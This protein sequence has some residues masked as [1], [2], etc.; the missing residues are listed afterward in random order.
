[1]NRL[2]F[3]NGFVIPPIPRTG[4]AGGPLSSGTRRSPLSRPLVSLPLGVRRIVAC[5]SWGDERGKRGAARSIGR[6]LRAIR[7]QSPCLR[8][9]SASGYFPSV[10][11]AFRRP[12]EKSGDHERWT[13]PLPSRS[14]RA[15]SVRPSLHPRC[16]L[17]AHLVAADRMARR[18]PFPAKPGTPVREPGS[19]GIACLPLPACGFHRRIF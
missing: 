2:K 6:P 15:A 10:R 18:L 11:R 1:M 4:D 12:I 13:V 19:S 7:P 5:A 16:G 14:N 8:H 17:P 3:W 9:Q